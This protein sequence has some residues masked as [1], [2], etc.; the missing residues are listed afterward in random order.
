MNNF[1]VISANHVTSSDIIYVKIKTKILIQLIVLSPPGR[2]AHPCFQHGSANFAC[3]LRYTFTSVMASATALG[4]RSRRQLPNTQLRRICGFG[5]S[6]AR[7]GGGVDT[8]RTARPAAP[9]CP[10]SQA[11]PPASAQTRHPHGAATARK[12]RPVT[13]RATPALRRAGFL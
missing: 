13:S 8:P 4:Q 3:E 5:G 7:R 1:P 10:A 9:R 12:P 2:H 11:V 6:G